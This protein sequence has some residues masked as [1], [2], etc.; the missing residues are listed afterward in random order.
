MYTFVNGEAGPLREG[1]AADV[2]RRRSVVEVY[3]LVSVQVAR[4]HERLVARRADVRPLAAV[5]TLVDRQVR[6]I[7][8][9]LPADV[10]HEGLETGVGASVD[11][12]RS[13]L[14]ERLGANF[15]H[16]HLLVLVDAS[17]PRE[18]RRVDE[19]F[20]T[21]TADK[22]LFPRVRSFV[23]VYMSGLGKR[24]EANVARIRPQPAVNKGVSRQTAGVHKQLMALKTLERLPNGTRCGTVVVG[25]L[26]MI[27]FVVICGYEQLFTADIV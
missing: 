2:A 24:F 11:V 12:Q 20:V 3:A 4:V 6:G 22:R 27:N 21:C 14:S 15:A 18:V 25:H 9:P 10:T 8:E 13:K 1:F 19:S 16:V 7:H 26:G 5:V 17:V 23:Y